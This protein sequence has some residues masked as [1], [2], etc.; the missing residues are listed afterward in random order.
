MKGSL[1]VKLEPDAPWTIHTRG[2]GFLRVYLQVKAK[3]ESD[4]PWTIH[5]RDIGFIGVYLHHLYITYLNG[6]TFSLHLYFPGGAI[7]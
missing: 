5:T 2:I 6:W 3:L 4:T 7:V 1:K